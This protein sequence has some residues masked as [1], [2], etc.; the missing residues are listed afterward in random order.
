MDPTLRTRTLHQLRETL[1]DFSRQMKIAA[2]YVV[3]YP[4]EFGI[5]PI[6]TSA[7]KS[8]VSTYTF[9]KMA[10]HL[11]FSS[12]EE[13]R[14]P[15]RHALVAGGSGAQNLDWL[16]QQDNPSE[17]AQVYSE[18]AANGLAIVTRSLERQQLEQ[19]ERIVDLLVAADTIYLTAVRSSFSVAYYF[20]YVGRMAMPSFHLIPRHQNSAI[21]DLN[22][23]EP[24][25]VLIAITVTPYSRETI[26]ACEFAQ[27]KG[28]T[29]VLI[30]D[31]DV[32][33]PDLKPD[34][35]LVTSVLSTHGFGCFSGMMAVVELLVA[36]LM[37]RGGD[38][39]KERIAAYETLRLQNNAYW[40]PRKKH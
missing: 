34:Y 7:S 17:L 36:L 1:P 9:V 4:A 27:K 6:R 32:V 13:M 31:S 40:A 15:F 29:I 28:A 37:K 16:N 23:I 25:Q 19:L 24:G 8:G 30:S 39:A 2:K 10:K 35:V 11:G 18:A 5:D 22:D 12:F 21:D 3:D 26:E 14:E 33:A 38:A 20:H